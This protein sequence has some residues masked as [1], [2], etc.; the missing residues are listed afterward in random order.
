MTLFERFAKGVYLLTLEKGLPSRKG[1][2]CM[3]WEAQG[4]LKPALSSL[5]IIGKGR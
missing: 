1:L 4:R 3:A 2:F 5:R